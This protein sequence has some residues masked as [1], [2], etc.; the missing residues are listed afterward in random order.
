MRRLRSTLVIVTVTAAHG[1]LLAAAVALALRSEAIPPPEH[2]GDA[3]SPERIGLAVGA[4]VGIVL[5]AGLLVGAIA[6]IATRAAPD[7]LGWQRLAPFT[8]PIVHRLLDRA[9]VVALGLG[10]IAAPAGTVA[11]AATTGDVPIVRVTLAA[12]PVGDR[13]VVRG[14]ETPQSTPPPTAPITTAPA[15]ATD[16][17]ESPGA[18]PLEH[19]IRPG[20]HLWSIAEQHLAGAGI[21][22]GTPSDQTVAR[23]WARL[24]AANRDHLRS[25]N[26]SLVFPGEIVI[27]PALT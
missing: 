6:T 19:V 2:W 26:P 5:A 16:P 20:E 18:A 10:T 4:V 13:P 24:V 12:D 14:P 9:L 25:G 1:A 11:A 17:V 22:A 3:R 21:E 8:L 7:R 15:R 23:Y 27:L